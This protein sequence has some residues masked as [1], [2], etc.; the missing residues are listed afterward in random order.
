MVVLSSF[1]DAKERPQKE[2]HQLAERY[3]FQSQESV[4]VLRGHG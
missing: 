4:G 1:L 3:G 2:Q